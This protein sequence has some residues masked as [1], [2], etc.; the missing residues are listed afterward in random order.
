MNE[1]FIQT[2][3]VNWYIRIFSVNRCKYS[4]FNYLFGHS[5]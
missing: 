1:I 5:L 4:L 2:L 3:I